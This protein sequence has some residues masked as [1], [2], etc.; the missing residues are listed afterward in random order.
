MHQA[1]DGSLYRATAVSQKG[2]IHL[3]VITAEILPDFPQELPKS[4]KDVKLS[5]KLVSLYNPYNHLQIHFEN[6]HFRCDNPIRHCLLVGPIHK[7]NHRSHSSR[8]GVLF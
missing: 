6:T 4:T 8:T 5:W 7:G 2:K 1:I 3:S